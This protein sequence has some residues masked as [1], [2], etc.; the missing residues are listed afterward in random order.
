MQTTLG[1]GEGIAGQLAKS[2][3]PVAAN[4]LGAYLSPD[5]AAAAGR[6][7]IRSGLAFAALEGGSPL[8]VVTLYAFERREASERLLDTLSAIGA[9]L[10]RFL[11]RHRPALEHR[12]L[13]SRELEILRCAAA[14]LSGPEIAE[15][16]F[17]SPATVKTHFTHIYEKL[18]IGDRAAAVAHALRTGLIS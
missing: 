13:S 8:A 9:H 18:G 5:R 1:A 11:Q 16:L 3:R 17:I 4:D 10:G 14:G 2:V 7:G 15:R 6:V 12:P